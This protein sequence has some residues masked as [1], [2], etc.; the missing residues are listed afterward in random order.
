MLFFIYAYYLTLNHKP[1][2]H[3]FS[4]L[5]VALTVIYAIPIENRLTDEVSFINVGQGDC[6]LIRHHQ[7]VVLI[8]TGGLTYTDLATNNLIPYLRK[9]RIYKIDSVIITHYDYDHYGALENLQKEYKIGHIYDYYSSFPIS[10][11]RLTFNNYNTY[12]VTSNEENDR[13][14]VLSFHVLNKDFVIMGDA[15]SWVEKKIITDY[16][17]ISCDILKIGHHGS[18][19]S[20]CE[21]FISYMHPKTAIVSCGKNNKFGH[22]SKS[23]VTTLNKHNIEIRR[24]DLEGTI[25]YKQF[26]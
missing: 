11:G 2:Q 13:S 6:T 16:N 5:L 10:V 12:G 26:S 15:P 20:S 14:L 22:P 1:L 24:T 19:T 8:D 18:D 21:E 3:C 23:V 9:K 4:L 17:S 7:K 25:T